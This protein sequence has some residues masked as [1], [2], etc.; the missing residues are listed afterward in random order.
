[1]SRQPHTTEQIKNLLRNVESRLSQGQT[2]AQVCQSL[3]I[4]QSSYRRWRIKY[5]ERAEEN[6]A[7]VTSGKTEQSA[8]ARPTS[9]ENLIVAKGPEASPDGSAPELSKEAEKLLAAANDASGPARNAWLAFLALLAYLLVTLGGVS[10][11]ELLLNNP[12][13]LPIVNVDIPLFSFFQ[14]APVLLLLVQ[15]SLLIQH[16][17][18][19]GKFHNF[20]EAI[21]P[22]EKETDLEHP[23]RQL[24]D[25]YV[26]SQ[27]LAGPKRSLLIRWLM[28]LMVFVTFVLLPIVTLLYFQ[29]K[30]LPYHE[31]WITYWHRIAVLLGLGL[32]FAVLPIIHLK[33]RKREVKVGPQGEAWQASPFGIWFGAVIATL[34]VGF[35]WLIATIPD[36]RLDR[37]TEFVSP[38]GLESR[39]ENELNPLVRFAYER[40]PQADNPEDPGWLL[41]WLMSYRVLVVE[42][43]YLVRDEGDKQAEVSVVLRK[44]NFRSARLSGSDLRRADLSEA[45][46]RGAEMRGTRLEKTKLEGAKLQGADLFKA[47][48]QGAHLSEA[49]LQGAEL[50]FAQ[51]Q[52]ADLA[53]VHLQGA[54]LGFAELQGADL[55]GAE[56][57][58]ANVNGAELQGANLVGADLQGA[59]LSAAQLQ[60]ADLAGAH[61]QGADLLRA[62]LQGADLVYAQLQGAD[63]TG[64][65]VWL[66]SFP[67]EGVPASFFIEGVPPDLAF[68]S[69]VRLGVADLNM[70]P[71]TADAKAQLRQQLRVNIID[72]KLLERLLDRLNPILRDDPPEWK[73]EGRWSEYIRQA[74]EPSPD[75]LV[76]ILARLACEDPE[77][78]I[79][80]AMAQRATDVGRHEAEDKGHFWIQNPPGMP[81]RNEIG[82]YAKPLAK[83]LLNENCR[84][85]KALTDKMRATLTELGSAPE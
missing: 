40:I 22:Y 81:P 76:P 26:V 39:P 55:A 80:I 68:L 46:L 17:M 28:R 75:E 72:D 24:V 49:Q 35:S 2:L 53:G 42:D 64:V 9:T 71:P 31:V 54:N 43:T 15:L 3:D 84:G 62:Q 11:K 27:I 25:P 78:H 30:F 18:L 10:D 16:V 56:I 67:I 5:H 36:E 34:I 45:D 73:D 48:L 85:A 12:V 63:L 83:A 33:S 58:G 21:A 82:H 32:L 51:L 1:M 47:Q 79:A 4:S 65:D 19:S 50:S 37:L 59:N 29:V 23:A 44:R 74:K 57:Q 7:V 41:R 70:S 52:G 69:P 38:I 66:A 6:A 14:Y 60:G 20:T 77:G 61:L 8:G 13:R